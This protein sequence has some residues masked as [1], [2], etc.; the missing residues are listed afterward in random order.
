LC[1][2]TEADLGDGIFPMEA[3]LAAGGSFAIGSDSLASSSP[4]EEL[5]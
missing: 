2:I 3:L 4:I 5:R 1:P